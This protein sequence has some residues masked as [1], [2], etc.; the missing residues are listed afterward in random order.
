MR[1]PW[2]SKTTSSGRCSSNASWYWKPEQPPPRT[3]TRSPALPTS[4]PCE[5]RNSRT[6]S[7][8]FSVNETPLALY[9]TVVELIAS[10]RIASPSERARL[11]VRDAHFRRHQ[12]PHRGSAARLHGR[13]RGLDGRRRPLPGD[14]RLPRL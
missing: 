7:A 12:V 13:G 1:S 10:Q 2:S 3:P 4:A 9:V 8:P 6:F 11:L 14:R 5:A